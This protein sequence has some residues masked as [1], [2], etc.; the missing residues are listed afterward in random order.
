MIRQQTLLSIGTRPQ[1]SEKRELLL[2]SFLEDQVSCYRSRLGSSINA[3]LFKC[4]GPEPI[5]LFFP[6]LLYMIEMK[7]GLLSFS[8]LLWWLL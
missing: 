8:L 2:P 1:A 6:L 4:A 3:S 5:P 7:S